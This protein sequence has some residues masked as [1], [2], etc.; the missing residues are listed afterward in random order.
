MKRLLMAT[1]LAC[2]LTAFVAAQDTTPGTTQ[3]NT[4][5]KTDTTQS[6]TA[7][8]PAAGRPTGTIVKHR[9]T[10]TLVQP[11]NAPIEITPSVIKAAQQK[12][13]EKG[14]S[15]GPADGRMGPQTR[16]AIEKFQADQNLSQTGKLDQKTLAA[17]NVGGVQELKAAPG[18]LGRGGKAIGHNTVGGH[19]VAAA[20]AAKNA[21]KNF[22]KKVG[23]GTESTAVKAKDKVGSGISAIGS[24]ISGAGEKTKN[25]G[26]NRESDQE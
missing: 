21:G 7:K 8:D 5:T 20:K 22:G 3:S 12:L 13:E 1:G 14:Y 2:A 6:T 19:P 26:E 11:A 24:K 23:Q 17:L 4:T 16:A 18:D 25:A 15:A 9:E 10:D